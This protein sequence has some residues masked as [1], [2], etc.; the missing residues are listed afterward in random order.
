MAAR[1]C[2]PAGSSSAYWRAS[3]A[4]AAEAEWADSRCRTGLPTSPRRAHISR[5]VWFRKEKK[6]RQARR[7]RLEIP[8][9]AWEKCEVCGH[10]DLREKFARNL[11][12]CPNCD[13][14]RRIR[15]RDYVDILLD[16]GVYEELDLEVK[17]VDP[18][19]F[20]EYPQRLSKALANAG[21]YDALLSASGTSGGMPINLGV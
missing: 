12:V 4:K 5:M 17:S 10:T 11:N 8:P 2:S 7:E 14:H 16:D 3:P 19:G 13:Y 6:P 9:D 15:A 1:S 20:P 21:D 18:L